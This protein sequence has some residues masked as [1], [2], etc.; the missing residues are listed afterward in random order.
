M[1]SKYL[2]LVHTSPGCSN[3]CRGRLLWIIGIFIF[4][5][6]W[7]ATI[8][9]NS[10]FATSLSEPL[11]QICFG[12]LV[13]LLSRPIR[14][15]PNFDKFGHADCQV[16]WANL[17]AFLMSLNHPVSLNQTKDSINRFCLFEL[18][19]IITRNGK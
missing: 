18:K 13:N 15:G 5:L 17:M 19:T 9:G 4:L 6:Q 2:S 8:A 11:Q 3:C 12:C 16:T 1:D 7:T 10:K 14:G